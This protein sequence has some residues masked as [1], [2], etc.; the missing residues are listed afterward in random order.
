[1]ADFNGTDTSDMIL[2]NSSGVFEIYD[3]ANN[4][5]TGNATVG[6][7]GVEWSVSGFGDFSSRAGETD[8]LM[9][10]SNTGA[11]EVYDISNNAITFATG[12]GQVGL[13]WQVSGFGDFSGRAG[14]TGDMLMRN[15]NTG[16]FEVYDISN[17]QITFAGP[18]WAKSG[19]NG[20][21]AGF[22]DFSGHANETDML[23]RNSNTGAFELYD[24]ANN[25]ITSAGPMGQV[26]LEWQVVGFGPMG[27]AGTSD[28]LMRNC[29]TGAFE[30]YDIV[31]NQNHGRGGRWAKSAASGRLPELRPFRPATPR[32][33]TRSLRRQWPRSPHPSARATQALHSANR[34][35][36]PRGR[37]Q[38]PHRTN[39]IQPADRARPLHTAVFAQRYWT[40]PCT[41]STA[42]RLTHL[43]R[44]RPIV[45]AKGAVEIG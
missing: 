32:P 39:R 24:I 14:E 34:K 6:Q 44:R 41:G 21:V 29:N 30:V 16:Q 25:Q 37:A 13:E 7:V 9:R 36:R 18:A 22:G 3:V 19:L 11:F 35:C 38:S 33:Q 10:N 20:Q 1:M 8:M 2:R 15:S 5:F 42:S 40:L 43:G 31:N 17:N 23:M 12:M 28:M 27:G 4:T 26:G 45:A